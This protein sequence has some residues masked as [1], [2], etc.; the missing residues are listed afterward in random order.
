MVLN[1]ALNFLLS[2]MNYFSCSRV[3]TPTV[4]CVRQHCF[5]PHGLLLC[6]APIEP[7]LLCTYLHP[8]L[9][10]GSSYTMKPSRMTQPHGASLSPLPP[11][12]ELIVH[13]AKQQQNQWVVLCRKCRYKNTGLK[14]R[15]RIPPAAAGSFQT[16][17]KSRMA[18]DLDF[19]TS[20][21]IVI[22]KIPA[23]LSVGLDSLL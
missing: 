21:N 1:N 5:M 17:D 22:C 10:S 20:K 2:P 8:T 6:S 9:W 23:I 19:L 16:L 4:L 15:V 18:L 13:L 11:L 14:R 3:T 12:S 7:S